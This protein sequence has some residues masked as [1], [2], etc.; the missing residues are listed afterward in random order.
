VETT[1]RLDEHL[2]TK[3]STDLEQQEDTEL[4]SGEAS[5]KDVTVQDENGVDQ[6][7]RPRRPSKV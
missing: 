5:E 4:P 3:E 2:E 7:P 1:K 6:A